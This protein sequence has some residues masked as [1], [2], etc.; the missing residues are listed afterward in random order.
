MSA[1]PTTVAAPSPRRIQT[2]YLLLALFNTLAA[3]LIW[4]IDTLFL[5]SAG[6]NNTQVFTVNA[7]FMV[8]QVLFEVPTGVIADVKGRRLS[9]LLGTVVLA[10]ATLLYLLNWYLHSPVWWWAISS[11]AIG[12]GFSFFSGATEAWLVDALEFAGYQGKLD[13]VMGRGQMVTGVAMLVGSVAGGVIAQVAALSVP[14]MLRAGLL[15]VTTLIAW[16][17]MKDWG[18]EPGQKQNVAKHITDILS[19]SVAFTRTNR[20]ARWLMLASPFMAG[21]SFYTFYAM[22]PFL[23]QVYGDSTAYSVAGLAA[24]IVAG[25]QI[26]GGLCVPYLQRFFSR[27]S[28]ILLVGAGLNVLLLVVVGILPHFALAVLLLCVWGLVSAATR[29]V[30]QAYLNGLIPTRQRATIL[31]FDALLGS[32]G[33][34]GVQPVLGRVADGFGY[35]TSFVIGGLM[36][37]VA[38]PFTWL[39]QR[40]KSPADDFTQDG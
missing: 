2:M 26:V 38:L 18:F 39:A 27:R 37:S 13:T 8:G 34:V 12:L 21:V 25:A 29:P 3:S 14:Y 5:L 19:T 16:F 7:F 1:R 4:G 11:M 22:Q 33:G 28:M 17:G 35:P 24:A 30:R 23:L 9:Y 32:A 31:S 6:L 10:I 40:E 36:S 20:T 15:L